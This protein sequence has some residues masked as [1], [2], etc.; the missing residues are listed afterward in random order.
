MRDAGCFPADTISNGDW[1]PNFSY[2]NEGKAALITAY[3]WQLSAMSDECYEWTEIIPAPKMTGDNIIDTTGH[4]IFT[5]GHGALF[6]SKDRWNE[7]K[8]NRQQLLTS[9][10]FISAMKCLRSATVTAVMGRQK[11]L[12][13]SDYSAGL[14]IVM[15]MMKFNEDNNL[16]KTNSMH[17]LTIPDSTVWA[18]YEGTLDEFFAGAISAEEYMN[19]VQESMDNN[20]NN[21]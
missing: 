17:M 9:I 5:G 2:Y 8:Q 11:L 7:E 1:A 6:I 16:T 10:I 15:D 3:G 19:K 21:K 20:S 12:K 13:I 4:K 14:P 18:D